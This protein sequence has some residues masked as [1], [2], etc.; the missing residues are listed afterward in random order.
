MAHFK[1]TAIT[2]TGTKAKGI[3]EADSSAAAEAIVADRGLIPTSVRKSRAK[4]ENASSLGAFFNKVKPQDI[5]L[6]TKQFRTLLGAGVPVTRALEILEAQTENKKLKT[7]IIEIGQEIRQGSPLHKAF[8]KRTDI[9]SELY[10]NMLQAGEISGTLMEVLERLIYIVEHENKVT[11]DIKSALTYPIIVMVALAIC[12]VVLIVFVLP[13]FINL[14]EQQNIELPWPTRICIM[15]NRLL[16]DYWPIIVGGMIGGGIALYYYFKSAKG[17][18]MR[19][20]LL[21]KLPILGMVFQKAAMAR[22]GSIFSILQSSG[23]TVLDTM[24]IVSKTIG[25]AAI[26]REFDKIRTQLEQGRGISE[27]LRKARYFTP[28]V[29]SM[30]AVG[31]ESGRI[32][33]MMREAAQHYDYEVEYAVSRMSELIGPILTA[34]LAVVVGFFAL[35]IFLPLTELMQNAMSAM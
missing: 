10:C 17:R 8:R 16:V 1:Y 21:L 5:I 13:T 30:I 18:L 19:D 12:F 14:F 9:F 20:R 25:N 4:T 15:V 34:G 27:P 3:V 33:E 31:E 22:F 11:K 28:M 32:E 24:D 23:V 6:F 7:C 35:A 2:A 26:S 29:I